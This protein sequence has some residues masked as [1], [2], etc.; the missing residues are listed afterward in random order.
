MIMKPCGEHKTTLVADIRHS[1][2]VVAVRL[3]EKNDEF[4]EAVKEL[5]FRWDWELRQ[6][7]KPLCFKTGNPTDRVA[8]AA[9][10]LLDAGFM[11]RLHDEN[12]ISKALKRDFEPEQVRWVVKIVGGT[13]D[14]WLR[15]S[16]GRKDDLYNEA[17]QLP[18]AKYAFN[19]INVPPDAALEVEDFAESYDF[20]LSQGAAE[21]IENYKSELASG[22]I[23]STP[24]REEAQDNHGPR[25][26]PK[27]R[28]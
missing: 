13:F 28:H 19:S 23:F 16:W 6:W 26:N 9:C 11:V 14:G 1:D 22:L 17:R 10:T 18:G 27:L 2:K 8:E 3:A 12:A 24:K 4:R 25:D 20:A 5:G 7:T 15:I 21:L